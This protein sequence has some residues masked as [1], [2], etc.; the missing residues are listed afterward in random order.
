MP[1]AGFL[2]S[3][4]EHARTHTPRA[5]SQLVPREMSQKQINRGLYKHYTVLEKRQKHEQRY[6]LE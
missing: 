2:S 1:K 5:C 4:H 3:I 6:T